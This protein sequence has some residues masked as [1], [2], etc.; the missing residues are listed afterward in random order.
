MAVR[1]HSAILLACLLGG[2]LTAQTPAKVDF[3]LDVQPLLKEHCIECHG[4]TQQTR[5]LRLDTRRNAMPNRV[6][7]NRASIVPGNSAGSLLYLK[8]IGKQAGS[9]MPPSGPLKPEQIN[10]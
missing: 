10:I 1:Y 7:A 3:A 8:L 5:G 2:P 9:Q 6:G 4:P